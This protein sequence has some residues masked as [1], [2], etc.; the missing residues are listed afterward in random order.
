[1]LVTIRSYAEETLYAYAGRHPDHTYEELC[2]CRL[3]PKQKGLDIK[4]SASSMATMSCAPAVVIGD[5]M[6]VCNLA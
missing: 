6:I 5:A 2:Q 4:A 1:M 3:H